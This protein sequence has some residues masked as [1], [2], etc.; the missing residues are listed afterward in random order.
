MAKFLCH[1]CDTTTEAKTRPNSCDTCNNWNTFD[2]ALE[3]VSIEGIQF[4]SQPVNLDDVPIIEHKRMKTGIEPVDDV[5]GGGFVEG[6]VY[7]LAGE[8]GIGKST[9]TAQICGAFKSKVLYCSAEESLEQVKMR[10][11]RIGV[12]GKHITMWNE[13]CVEKIIDYLSKKKIKFGVIDSI[14]VMRSDKCSSAVGS[15]NQVR[16]AGNKLVAFA[17]TKGVTIILIAHVT[18]D[19]NVAGPKTIEHMVDAMMYF[20]QD[21]ENKKVRSLECP[22]KNRFAEVGV[23][24]IFQMGPTGLIPWKTVK[25]MEVRS[26]LLAVK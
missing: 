16:E 23:R 24:G 19:G 2:V 21:E 8:P 6:G 20:T 4:D 10:T 22:S 3:E 11:D 26:E 9:I 14:Q 17:K 12:S 15:T 25:A 1:Y 13:S 18:K 5:T 7:L